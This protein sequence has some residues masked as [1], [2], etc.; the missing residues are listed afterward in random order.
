MNLEKEEAASRSPAILS[1]FVCPFTSVP[2][3]ISRWMKR[4]DPSRN[5]APKHN[6]RDLGTSIQDVVAGRRTLTACDSD[7]GRLGTLHSPEEKLGPAGAGWHSSGWESTWPAHLHRPQANAEGEAQMNSVCEASPENVSQTQR[8]S[9]SPIQ[10][11]VSIPL[12]A[13][14]VACVQIQIQNLY[15]SSQS[16]FTY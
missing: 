7:A 15:F 16:P 5:H 11:F 3:L 4:M 12:F 9:K 1:P 2:K 6:L 8:L 14:C 13:A 10:K